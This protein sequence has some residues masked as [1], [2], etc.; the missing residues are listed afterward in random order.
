MSDAQGLDPPLLP[1]RERDEEAEFDQFRDR[2]V[3]VQPLPEGVV[4]D[5]GIPDD[6][7]G[8][9]QGDLLALGEPVG[10]GEVQQFI[11]LLFGE[12]LPSSLDG[13]L[14]P[15]VFALDRF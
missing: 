15:S 8:V 4:R 6:G 5:L 3:P 14:D 9:G 10:V 11:V 13:S 12:S 1:Q 2:E 7:A